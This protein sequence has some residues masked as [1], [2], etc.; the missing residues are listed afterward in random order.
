M[1]CTW[2]VK[3]LSRDWS[4]LWLYKNKLLKPLQ[5]WNW[6][7]WV[8]K[9]FGDLPTKCLERGLHFGWPECGFWLPGCLG[10]GTW[11]LWQVNWT[12]RKQKGSSAC[13]S[14]SGDLWLPHRAAATGD[15]A[16][17]L[18]GGFFHPLSSEWTLSTHL[19]GSFK[20]EHQRG[21]TSTRRGWRVSGRSVRASTSSSTQCKRVDCTLL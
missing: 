3:L 1:I 16:V 21:T 12:Q 20:H 15:D 14:A 9:S 19:W 4:N 8:F 7:T 18:A 5:Y 10:M 11:S 6:K 13:L 2:F 17:A